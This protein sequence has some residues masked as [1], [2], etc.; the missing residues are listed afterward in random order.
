[1]PLPRK[2]TAV[3]NR[4]PFKKCTDS[5]R[6][7]EIGPISS[8]TSAAQ[9]GLQ[10]VDNA[11]R[12]NL[13]DCPA[14]RDRAGRWASAMPA[15]WALAG[16]ASSVMRPSMIQCSRWRRQTDSTR[17]RPARSAAAAAAA[18]RDRKQTRPGRPRSSSRELRPLQGRRRGSTR[19]GGR[20]GRI[21]HGLGGSSRHWNL[22]PHS[23]TLSRLHWTIVSFG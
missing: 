18:A 10:P 14:D 4:S 5:E 9:L 11:A 17:R 20:A 22:L 13:R 8:V 6:G 23:L 3:I 21:T 19:A 2:A 12:R 16:G 1:M 7:S 15:L